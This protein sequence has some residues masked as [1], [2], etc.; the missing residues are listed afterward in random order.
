MAQPTYC[1]DRPSDMSVLTRKLRRDLIGNAGVLLT[2]FAIIAVGTGSFIG[3]GSA[4]RILE[5]SQHSYY[6]KYQFA[7]F[8]VEV[9]KAP[10]TTLPVIAELPGVASVES[11]VVFDLIMD[12]PGVTQPITGRLISAPARGFDKTINGVHLLRGSGFS[13]DRQA[14]VIVGEA[15]ARARNLNPGDRIWL[16]LNRKRESFIIV[17]TAISP[18]YV[19]MVRGPGDFAPDPQHFGILYVKEDYARQVLDFKDSC[20]QIVGRL[21]PGAEKDID[22]LLTRIDR[23]LDPYGVLATTPRE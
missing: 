9:K 22:V 11:R 8:W 10:L 1:H 2:V 14:E 5:T 7:D 15:F 13:D 16:I 19:Y 21:V 20:N 4:Q 18:E 12:I 3:L 17:G 23:I 6:N